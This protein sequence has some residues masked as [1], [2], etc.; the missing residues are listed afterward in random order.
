MAERSLV[1]KV[2]KRGFG[3]AASVQKN[4]QTVCSVPPFVIIIS[5]F[6]IKKVLIRN[7]MFE[8]FKFYLLATEVFIDFLKA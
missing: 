4:L 8:N 2:L 6:Y 3:S 5:Q 7:Q 1:Q